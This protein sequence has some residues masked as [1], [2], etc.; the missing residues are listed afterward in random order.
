MTYRSAP[1]AA[2]RCR[3]LQVVAASPRGFRVPLLKLNERHWRYLGQ[4]LARQSVYAT[5]CGL[6]AAAWFDGC[7]DL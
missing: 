6:E 1:Q 4:P 2:A 3:F 5:A 7:G